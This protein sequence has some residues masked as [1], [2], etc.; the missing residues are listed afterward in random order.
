MI[1]F[2]IASASAN[3]AGAKDPFSYG[4]T[5]YA[6]VITWA[7]AGGAVSFYQKMVRGDARAFN[8]TELIGEIFTS[9]FVGVLTFWVCEANNVAPLISAAIIGISGHMGARLI[10]IAEKYLAKKY[11]GGDDSR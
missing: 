11:G 8:F 2:L 10:F 4:W 9:A 6:W 7:G 5:I 3:A 1:D